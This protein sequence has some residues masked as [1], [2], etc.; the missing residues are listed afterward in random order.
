MH[1]FLVITA[2]ENRNHPFRK[3]EDDSKARV[4]LKYI[5]HTFWDKV[6]NRTAVPGQVIK[7]SLLGSFHFDQS[8]GRRTAFA[9][10]FPGQ[11]TKIGWL[12]CCLNI[13][14]IVPV[15][16]QNMT[17]DITSNNCVS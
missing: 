5:C 2:L 7:K 8:G 3:T 15:Q 1:V 12:V 4:I 10:C 17:N 9:V 6:H 13:T 14:C 16:K 11:F